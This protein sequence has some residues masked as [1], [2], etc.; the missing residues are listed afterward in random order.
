MIGG[1]DNNGLSSSLLFKSSFKLL[2]QTEPLIFI[3]R[4]ILLKFIIFISALT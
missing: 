3:K 4:A 2:S 1:H